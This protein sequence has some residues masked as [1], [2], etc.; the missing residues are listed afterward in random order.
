M[1]TQLHLHSHYSLLDAIGTPNNYVTKATE[2]GMT[3]L[4][5]TDYSGMYGVIEFYKACKKQNIQPIL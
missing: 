5:L 3:A 4:S 2:L 1:F